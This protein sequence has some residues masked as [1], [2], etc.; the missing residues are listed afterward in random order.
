MKRL[1]LPILF[2]TIFYSTFAQFDVLDVGPFSKI[3]IHPY[4]E[5]ELRK[6]PTEKVELLSSTV[7]LEKIN[8]EVNG[9][10]LHMYL[11]DAKVA[12]K[13]IIKDNFDPYHYEKVKAIVTY[14]NLQKLSVFGEEKLDFV[15]DIKQ[16]KF[17][18]K[19]YGEVNANFAA[20]TSEKLKIGFYGE[21][22]LK[23]DGGSI[24]KIV[25]AAYG[26]NELVAKRLS[27]SYLKFTNFGNNKLFLGNQDVMKLTAFGDATI[28]FVGSPVL[29]QKIV[30]GEMTFVSR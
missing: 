24:P 4:F 27:G 25:V 17:Q 18:L 29:D 26:E 5:V 11:E 6:G 2:C 8:I 15:D 7:D 10:T 28:S 13:K 22:K 1:F 23:V 9:G 30:I 3:M 14:K 12:F 16:R 20:I 21:N 19:I